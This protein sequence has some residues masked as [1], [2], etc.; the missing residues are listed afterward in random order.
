MGAE[1]ISVRMFDGHVNRREVDIT[2]KFFGP[3][4]KNVLFGMHKLDSGFKWTKKLEAELNNNFFSVLRKEFKLKPGQEVEFY[5]RQLKQANKIVSYLINELSLPEDMVALRNEVTLYSDSPALRLKKIADIG[6]VDKTLRYEIARQMF[7]AL[8]VAPLDA[9]AV[10]DKLATRL[11]NLQDFLDDKLFVGKTGETIRRDVYAEHNNKTNAVN[12]YDI[13]YPIKNEMGSHIKKHGLKVRNT[14]TGLEVLTQA[15]H[16]GETIALIKALEKALDRGGEVD[17]LGSVQDSIGIQL[18]IMG[19]DKDRNRFIEHFDSLIKT[20]DQYESTE[21]D[22]LPDADRGQNNGVFKARKK[23][24]LKGLS[25]PVEVMFFSLPEYLDY[26]YEVGDG[27]NGRAH[28]LYEL[29]RTIRA[30]SRLFPKEI[31]GKDFNIDSMV[32]ERMLMV[33]DELR[34]KNSWS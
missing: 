6:G 10:E 25:V 15:R 18:T 27:Y 34:F 5:R 12:R 29:R 4:A 7:L 16:K 20:Y 31:Y 11:T 9:R 17:V 28:R 8:A 1:T 21:D 2:S 33:S 32:R 24:Y 22:S 30:A 14:T 3:K 23:Y 13:G 19:D 26:S